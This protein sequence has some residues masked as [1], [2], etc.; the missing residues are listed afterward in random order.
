MS[1]VY[2]A[3]FFNLARQIK[4]RQVDEFL[5]QARIVSNPHVESESAQ[6]FI[7]DLLEQ[8]DWYRGDPSQRNKLDRVGMEALKNQVRSV[9]RF[10]K[11]RQ[12]GDEKDGGVIE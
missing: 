1:N 12:K 10:G 6:E 7:E 9:S 8:R 11:V 5:M 3:D 2:P 4:M